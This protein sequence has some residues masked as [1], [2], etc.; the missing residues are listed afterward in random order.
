MF[1]TPIGEGAGVVILQDGTL[2]GGDSGMFYIGTYK[3]TGTAFEATVRTGRHT[4]AMDS[5]LGVDN[6]NLS[7][8][9]TFSGNAANLNGT[10]REAPGIAFQA[11]ISRLGD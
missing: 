6:A 9:G 5:V 2:R 1:K 11:V 7:L 3:M 4:G 10:A 8:K